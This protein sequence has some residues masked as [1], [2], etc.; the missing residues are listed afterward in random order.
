MILQVDGL[1]QFY[2]VNILRYALG[3][4]LCI[5]HGKHN[6][7]R[8]VDHIASGK[9]ALAAR[10]AAWSVARKHISAL[11]NVYSLGCRHNA[12]GRHRADCHQHLVRLLG[13]PL[14]AML[15]HYSAK[16]TVEV[17]YL[18]K[19]RLPVE[20]HTFFHRLV[21]FRTQSTHVVYRLVINYLHVPGTHPYCSARSVHGRVSTPKDKHT[22]AL[23]HR[24]VLTVYA[25]LIVKT[26]LP[27]EIDSLAHTTQIAPWNVRLARLNRTRTHENRV[28]ALFEAWP[29][30]IAALFVEPVAGNMGLMLPQPGFLE[31]LREL[32]TRYGALLVFDE[33]ITGFRLS[34]GG[35]QERFHIMPDLTTFG[36]IIGGG[37]PVGAYGGRADLMRHIAPEGEVYQAGTLSGNPLAMAA[38]LATLNILKHADYA[39]LEARVDAFVTE[40]ERIL[41]EKGVPVQIPHIASLFT[42]YF[43][44]APLRDFAS[45][46]TT[47]QKLFES[48]YKQMREQGIFMAPSAFEANMLSFAHSDEDFA[49]ALE[50]ARHVKF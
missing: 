15:Y 48:F 25:A 9:H 22:V 14:A 11:I 29:D 37:L 28:K 47:D 44:H 26:H 20:L 7:R 23:L 49:R 38:G 34:Y 32:C 27:K 18:N 2:R 3:H 36:K 16:R 41:R 24:H 46:Q 35:A 39:A 10:H 19:V 6:G 33:V 31:G 43:T 30:Q 45:V 13:A 50:A 42:V 40:L 8:T 12:A 4:F 5:A 17:K 1:K 21:I